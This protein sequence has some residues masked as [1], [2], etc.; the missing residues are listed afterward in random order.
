MLALVTDRERQ[1]PEREETSRKKKQPDG[2]I[3][4]HI[5]ERELWVEIRYMLLI[6][7]R[8]ESGWG[9]KSSY[10]QSTNI[11]QRGLKGT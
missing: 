1:F 2:K 9:E 7:D 8:E 11:Q 6:N 5:S 3:S 4:L 10:R